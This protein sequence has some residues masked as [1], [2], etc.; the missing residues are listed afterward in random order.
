[1]QLLRAALCRS[2]LAVAPG[3][4]PAR[5]SAAHRGGAL[6]F[7]QELMER[8]VPNQAPAPIQTPPLPPGCWHRAGVATSCRWLR[9]RVPVP[10]VRRVLACEFC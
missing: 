5:H 9:K 4:R 2:S 10:F 6:H 8:L 7:I 1:M 3:C